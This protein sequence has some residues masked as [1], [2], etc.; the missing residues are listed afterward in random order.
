MFPEILT[1]AVWCG[2]SSAPITLAKIYNCIVSG[3]KFAQMCM[4]TLLAMIIRKFEVSTGYTKL[5]EL[6]LNFRVSSQPADGFKLTLSPRNSSQHWLP[7]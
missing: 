3:K 2:S 5:E 7:D 4:A 1:V 6:K